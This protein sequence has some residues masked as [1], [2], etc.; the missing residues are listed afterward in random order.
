MQ[1]GLVILLEKVTYYAETDGISLEH[2][3]RFGKFDMRVKHFHNEYEIF[4]ILE[5][6]R[7]FFFNNRSFVA[8]K[9]DLILVDANLIH[10]TKSASEDDLGHNRIIL[11]VTSAKMQAIDQLYPRLQLVRFFHENYGVYHLTQEQ[12]ERFMDLYYFLK[13]EFNEKKRSFKEAI[14]LAVI[15]YLLTLPRELKSSSQEHPKSMEEGKYRT[16]YA[17]ADFLSNN[18]EKNFSLDELA[19]RFFL[20]K[21]YVC[22]VFK[23]VTGYTI[24]EYINIHRI[25]KAKRYLEETDISISEIAQRLGY[26]SITHFEKNFKHYMTIS[27]LKYRKSPNTVTYTNLPDQ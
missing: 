14:D 1:P 7:L 23:D 20:S 18:C 16:A 27:P 5:G 12:Q 4:Y 22:R 26:G 6:K 3:V 11:Y 19:E 24:S 21:Y 9:G 10:M 25:L 13:K 2:M 8:S 15:S 17:I